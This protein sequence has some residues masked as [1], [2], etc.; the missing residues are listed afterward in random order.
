MRASAPGSSRRVL[1]NRRAA[2]SRRV[3]FFPPISRSADPEGQEM[4]AGRGLQRFSRMY[5]LALGFILP[6]LAIYGVF[7]L[8]PLATSL[9]GSFFQWRAL[10]HLDFI[11]LGNFSRLFV[12]PY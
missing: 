1:E 7:V 3:P 9:W 10:R 6:A 2:A 12:F 8:Y 11:G 5:L 4:G